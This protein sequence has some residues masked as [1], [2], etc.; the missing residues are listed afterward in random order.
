LAPRGVSAI[1]TSLMSL[2]LRLSFAR[3]LLLASCAWMIGATRAPLPPVI[4]ATT[5]STHD[6][7]LLDDLIPP[8]EARSGIKVKVIAVGSGQAMTLG[9]H[10]EA[11][12]LLVHAPEG[13]EHFMALGAG[14]LRRRM[15]FNDFVLVGPAADPAGLRRAPDLASALTALQRP[16]AIFVS[17]GDDSGTHQVE[18]KLWRR[19]GLS[20]PKGGHYL[21]TGQGM[22][23]TLRVAS[24]KE[25]YTLS[26]RGTFLALQTTLDLRV[27]FEGDP[28]LRNVY[29]VIVVNPKQGP[30]V[31]KPGAMALAGYLLSEEALGRVRQ[32]GRERFGRSLFVPDAEPLGPEPG[33]E[34]GPDAP[35]P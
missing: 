31:N 9:L 15:M 2:P 3:A 8:F 19:A 17:R 33:P 32:F 6:S 22:G 35:H 21:E 27:L 11:D 34:G 24:E 25:A 5:T 16:E 29:H 1:I 20:P 18:L 28:V 26:D 30:R 10:G 13:E 14:L 7:G 23:A 4:L 12:L